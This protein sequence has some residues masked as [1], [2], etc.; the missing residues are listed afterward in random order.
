M[1]PYPK[2]YSKEFYDIFGQ[3][4]DTRNL[5]TINLP[6]KLKLSWD[7]SVTVKRMTVHSILVDDIRSAFEQILKAYG[8]KNIQDLRL[9][10][11]GGC[12]N[13]RKITDGDKWSIHAWGA[14]LDF[15]PKRNKFHWNREQ[16]QLALS[17]YYKFWHIWESLGWSSLGREKD[18]DYQHIQA[19]EF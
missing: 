16:A 2:Q 19:P 10:I 15:D 4:G 3:V 11:F 1:K 13:K 6:F 7:E 9:D 8:L 5:L 18:F 12:Y 17:E 14:A